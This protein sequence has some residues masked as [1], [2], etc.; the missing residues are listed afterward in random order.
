MR[1][2]ADLDDASGAGYSDLIKQPVRLM[3]ELLRLLLQPR[4]FRLSVAE[5]VLI[6][7]WH[8]RRF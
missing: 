5:N 2:A 1:T 8:D 3:R 7:L 4:L 6:G